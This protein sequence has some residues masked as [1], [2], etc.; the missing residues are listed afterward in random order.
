MHVAGTS[1][2][3][4]AHVTV[5]DE[6]PGIPPEAQDKVFR[7]F[8]QLDPHG[9]GHSGTGMGLAI[10]RKIVER[11][12]GEIWGDSSLGEGATFHVTLHLTPE[13]TP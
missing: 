4:G 2:N 12:E 6:G 3:G 7:I 9:T 11:H 5:R 1:E 8:S 10:T 13:S